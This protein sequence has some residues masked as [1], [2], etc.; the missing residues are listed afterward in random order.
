MLWS[1][2][3]RFV[4]YSHSTPS[5]VHTRYNSLEAVRQSL[6]NSHCRYDNTSLYAAT[7]P[8]RQSYSA[9]NRPHHTYIHHELP[10]LHPIQQWVTYKLATLVHK[11]VL[12][13]TWQTAVIQA[14]TDV[15]EWDQPRTTYRAR[16]L[17]LVTGSLPSLV[18][19][20]GTTYPMPSEIRLSFLTFTKLLKS[21]LF[22]WLPQRVDFELAPYKCTN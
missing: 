9:T 10:L 14:L 20:P 19:A 22:V 5:Y 1:N 7:T 21:Y 13:S 15:Q 11:C 17:H 12:R 3:I 18:H 6:S 16:R 8:S 4:S 2:F